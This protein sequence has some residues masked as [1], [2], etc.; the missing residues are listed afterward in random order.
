MYRLSIATLAGLGDVF[1]RL[2]PMILCLHSV[3][4]AEGA[5]DFGGDLS[6]TDSFLED[7]IIYLRRRGIPILSLPEAVARIE[8]GIYDPFVSFTFDDG[9]RN[10]YSYAFPVFKRHKAPFTVFVTTGLVDAD[11]P[12]WWHALEKAVAERES[13]VWPGGRASLVS[14]RDRAAAFEV[15]RRQFRAQDANGQRVLLNDLADL[16]P[17]M[18]PSIAYTQGLTWDMI[19]DMSS[20]AFVGF[21]CHTITHPLLSLLPA[22]QLEHEIRGSRERLRSKTGVEAPF[23]AYPYGQPSEIGSLAP[24]AARDAGFSAA[25]TTVAEVLK[26][27]SAGHAFL[28]PRVLLSQKAQSAKVVRGYMS[29]YPSAL[30][31]SSRRLTHTVAAA[32]R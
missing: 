5:N 11:V 26:P 15:V 4:S 13:L 27:A 31:R 17:G 3:V 19:E 7:L 23:F 16:N 2:H 28:L 18:D 14:S 32:W 12:M 21:G 24:D 8:R 20:H 1:D 30:K 22:S 29:G 6:V 10:V 9:Y 25:F